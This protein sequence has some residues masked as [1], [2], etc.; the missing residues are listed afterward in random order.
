MGR[1]NDWNTQTE[2]LRIRDINYEWNEI[3]WFF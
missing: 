1:F 2:N 3:E